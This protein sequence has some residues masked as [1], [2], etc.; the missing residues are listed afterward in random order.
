MVDEDDTSVVTPIAVFDNESLT[1]AVDGGC[2]EAGPGLQDGAGSL[3]GDASLASVISYGG[4]SKSCRSSKS[5]TYRG[6]DARRSNIAVLR[7]PYLEPPIMKP[8]R[9]DDLGSFGKTYK[10]PTSGL[11]QFLRPKSPDPAHEASE[12]RW[13]ASHHDTSRPL[14]HNRPESAAVKQWNA[15]KGFFSY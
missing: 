3:I 6:H 10:E 8:L 5:P 14:N 11:Q 1:M 12:K 7:S 15:R 2:S 9:I 13:N 4:V